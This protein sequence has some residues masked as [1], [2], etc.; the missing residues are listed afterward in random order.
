MPVRVDIGQASEAVTPHGHT[1]HLVTLNDLSVD[2]GQG[3]RLRHLI[4]RMAAAREVALL[5][6]TPLHPVDPSW[7]FEQKAL[8]GVL[9]AKTLSQRPFSLS[10]IQQIR[11]LFRE[12]RT[13]LA[14]ARV[15]YTDQPLAVLCT[16][17]IARQAVS[18]IE[19]NGI[20]CEEWITKGRVRDRQDMRY[21]IIRG[22]EGW[23]LRKAHAVIAVSPG[24]QDYIIREFHVDPAR[25]HVI[26]NGLDMAAIHRAANGH[27]VRDRLGVDS[28]PIALFAGSFRA[29]HGVHNLI[30][31]LPHALALVPTLKLVL[32]GDG[33]TRPACETL[34]D[35]LGLR[36]SVVF[37]GHQPPE[38]VPGLIAA[39]DVCLYYPQYNVQGY[40]FM[41]DP[42]KLREYMAMGKP[43]VTIRFPNLAEIVEAED[44]GRVI[45]G[46]H[47]AF[48][49]A[50][51]E[52]ILH[53]AQAIQLGENG[54]RA[55]ETRYDWAVITNQILQILDETS[56]LHDVQLERARTGRTLS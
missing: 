52:L 34:V 6:P 36:G 26:P 49:E 24:L 13:F 42:I 30:R 22:I 14:N 41:G 20:Y 5:A 19:V 37:T 35:E 39:A 40:G 25:V 31:A 28:A 21:R 46:G 18:A 17:Y 33:P 29:W 3:V 50:M 4:A 23:A 27:H 53:P 32:V 47:R 43:I 1:I 48:G 44:C 54:R 10:G 7:Q 12:M 15:V 55:V 38:E 51:A 2:S 11:M 45:E 9:D 16:A 8:Y 56:R